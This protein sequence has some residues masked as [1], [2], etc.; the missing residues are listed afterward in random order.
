MRRLVALVLG[1]CLVAGLTGAYLLLSDRPQIRV[2]VEPGGPSADA[3]PRQTVFHVDCRTLPGGDA[4]AAHP[5]NSLQAISDHG[6]FQAGDRILLARSSTCPGRIAPSGSGS[7]ASPITL[8]AYGE[9]TAPLVQ[10]GG[11]SEGTG[12]VELTDLHDW[13][14]EDLQVTNRPATGQDGAYRAGV[15]AL[16]STGGRLTGITIQRVAVE[17]VAS[18][19]GWRDGVDP[20]EY[21]GISLLT[22][23]AD[24]SAGFDG[25]R[26]VGNRVERVGRV[27]IVSWNGSY[28][29][30]FDHDV[31]ITD[32]SVSWADG[33]S[34]LM[35]GTDG[36]T[37]ARNTSAYN[38]ALPECAACHSVRGNTASAGIWPTR[39]RNVVVE[40]NEVYGAHAAKGDG[41]GLDVD[42]ETQN[43]TVQRNYVHDNEGGGV[44]LC[45]ASQA[46]VRA[47]IFRDNGGAAFMFN[48]AQPSSAITIV[49]NDVYSGATRPAAVVRTVAGRG[50]TGLVF[51]NNLVFTARPAAWD[52]PGAVALA[53]NSLFGAKHRSSPKGA[54]TA[55]PSPTGLGAGGTG[56]A[57]I[58]AQRPAAGAVASS[59]LGAGVLD[60]FG[61]PFDPAS[62]GRGAVAPAPAG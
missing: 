25:A 18:D 27:G 38:G 61:T 14:V 8:G 36:G 33:D 7:A 43:V 56:M 54:W 24:P 52:W 12:A 19:P 50:A 2:E 53:N 39:A 32:N 29:N 40:A 48:C 55:G 51:Q 49:N 62:P 30:T 20:H 59:P 1:V 58:S 5:W 15:L 45:A 23:S 28:P 41:E 6:P 47:N 60:F 11:T 44:L 42:L 13:T 26:I 4:T 22:R 31:E 46:T 17:Q 35:Y 3:V 57:T 16:N 10:G 37:I 9:G 34:I 21:G